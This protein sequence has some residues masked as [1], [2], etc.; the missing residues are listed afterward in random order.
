MPP[1]VP[2]PARYDEALLDTF[3]DIPLKPQVPSRRDADDAN[4][5]DP[6]SKPQLS[7]S[8]DDA[9]AEAKTRIDP[10]GTANPSRG[11]TFVAQSVDLY[12]DRGLRRLL[13]R[14]D[15]FD[16]LGDDWDSYGSAPPNATAKF[17]ARRVLEQ[18]CH[19]N[20]FPM[21]INPSSDEGISLFFQFGR[22]RASIECLNS[23]EVLAVVSESEETPEVWE[24][25]LAEAEGSP[26]QEQSLRR[27]TQ[28]IKQYLTR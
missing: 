27:H 2:Q 21:T 12:Q 20:L 19:I 26:S 15:N 16:N 24:I 4:I 7:S 23:G 3:E 9:N 28:Y 22:R 17:L 11:T 8:Q 14:F 18:L 5:E 25:P 1:A 13:N 6:K 10:L